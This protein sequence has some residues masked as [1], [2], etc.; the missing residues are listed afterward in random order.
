M[1]FVPPLL[2]AAAALLV[3]NLIVNET[4][5]RKLTPHF[6]GFA[7]IDH[8][9]TIVRKLAKLPD[10]H[11][12]PQVETIRARAPL[13][14]HLLNTAFLLDILAFVRRHQKLTPWRHEN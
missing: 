7:Q 9:L 4:C 6:L 1:I 13:A 8:L 5:G 3:L 14:M 12:L 11:G 2:L 10:T